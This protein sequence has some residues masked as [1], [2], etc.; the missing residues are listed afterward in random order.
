MSGSAVQA[1]ESPLSP[2]TRKGVAL[3]LVFCAMMGNL[4]YSIMW[5]SVVVA[6]PIMQGR[7]AAT[8]DQITW[9][10]I[11]FV[12]GSAMVTAVVG[13]FA[14][15]FGRRRIYIWALGLY[16]IANIGCGVSASLESMVFWRFMQ[17]MFGAP[18]VPISQIIMVSAFP[19]SQ[20][21]R[22]VSIWAI[23]FIVGNLVSPTLA[24]Y[25]I[26]GIG[27]EWI[28]FLIVPFLITGFLLALGNLKESDKTD[29]KL[30][31]F[32]FATLA[33]GVGALQIAL[34]RGERLGWL[35]SQEVLVELGL[36]AI[37]LYWFLTHT[38][39]KNR[40]FVD[41]RL[42][43]DRNF[44]LGITFIF[45]VGLIMYLPM[46]FLPIML[47][48]IGGYPPSEVGELLLSRGLGSLTTLM[49]MVYLRE[50]IN[51]KLL[52][53]IGLL[54]VAV[55]TWWMSRWTVDV[56]R[57]EVFWINVFQG[58]S[59]GFVWSPLN[60]FSLSRLKG[61]LQ[62]KGTSLFYLMFDIGSAIGT[63]I[64]VT[65]WTHSVAINRA[66][67]SENVTAYS[68]TW[69]HSPGLD[70]HRLQD[71]AAI[72]NEMTRQSMVIAF[73]NSYY[74]MGIVVLML[75]PAILFF[76]PIGSAESQLDENKD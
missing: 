35:D 66:W 14:S 44:S 27:L 75:I 59:A 41:K 38:I 22:A 29:E 42:F 52:L 55:P 45:M 68:E 63:A 34:A 10:M 24:G 73:N 39:T 11:S 61:D 50:R 8:P 6:L 15:R 69:R 21:S 43:K 13:W 46:I 64:M 17:G 19:R 3:G 31:W 67:I 57:A 25:I 5:N 47:Q 74:V 51:P 28:F 56:A 1:D 72:D 33:L 53:L 4:S 23:G 18:L 16:M 65:F 9:V 40:T 48:S 71:L 62:D 54:M 37:L 30:D 49:M 7:F 60:R 20:Y 32:G 12:M 76:K 58:M 26:D 36:A 2:E 70:I